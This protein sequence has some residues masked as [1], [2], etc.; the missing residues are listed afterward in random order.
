[1]GTIKRQKISDIRES[2]MCQL[3]A[4]DMCTPYYI[5]M[6]DA[7]TELWKQREAFRKDISKRGYFVT[8]TDKYGNT[9]NKVNPS[10]A[11]MQGTTVK[12]AAQIIK[13]GF[14]DPAGDDDEE[15]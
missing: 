9:W 2:L 5:D 8:E 13:L 14:N 1:M 12:M 11:A 15:M 6:V 7:Y 10:V 3:R 4:K